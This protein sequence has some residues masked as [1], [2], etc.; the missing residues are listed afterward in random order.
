MLKG[1]QGCSMEIH[2]L[3]EVFQRFSGD[4]ISIPRGFKCIQ[5]RS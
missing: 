1:V 5:E 2:K 3:T 4:F